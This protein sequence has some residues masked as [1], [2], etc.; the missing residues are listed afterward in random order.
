SAWLKR[1]RAGQMIEVTSHRKVIARI[2]GVPE[3]APA[4][5]AELVASGAAQWRGGKPQ[6]ADVRLS[7]AAHSLAELVM[8]GRG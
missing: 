4:S 5:V 8:Q 2:Q 6:G 1:A 7:D 3:A